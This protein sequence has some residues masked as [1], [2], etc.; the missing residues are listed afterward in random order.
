VLKKTET[1]YSNYRSYRQT[2]R[3]RQTY[4]LNVFKQ[5]AT[6]EPPNI[7]CLKHILSIEYLYLDNYTT[8]VQN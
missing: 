1:D 7:I 5:Q 4:M 2:E 6:Q 3:N 8:Y